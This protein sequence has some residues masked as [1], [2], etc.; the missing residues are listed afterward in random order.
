MFKRMIEAAVE[1]ALDHRNLLFEKMIET[2]IEIIL[3]RRP[4]LFRKVIKKSVKKEL[5]R[6]TVLPDKTLMQKGFHSLPVIMG[7]IYDWVFVPFGG[8]DMLVEVRYVCADEL[9]EVDKLSHIF[10][11]EKKKIKLSRQQMIDVMN[12]Q[13]ECCKAVLNCP[14]FEELEQA[15]YSK[16]NVQKNRRKELEE[17]RERIKT[18]SGYEKQEQ[19]I[20]IDRLELYTGYILPKDT[21]HVLTN[22]AFGIGISDIKKVTKEKLIDAFSRARLYDGRPS[23]YIPGIFTDGDRKNIDDYATMLGLEEESKTKDRQK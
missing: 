4:D 6:H 16:D 19:Q 10:D 8:V 11:E 9:P 23:D 13:E 14:T 21:M 20:R 17:L 22:I 5:R 1:K 18:S 15:I 3:N 2:T 12:I 7:R